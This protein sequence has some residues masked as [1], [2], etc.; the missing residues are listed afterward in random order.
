MQQQELFN[1][2]GVW[3]YFKHE[4]DLSVNDFFIRDILKEERHSHLGGG[5]GGRS[6]LHSLTYHYSSEAATAR[7]QTRSLRL[8]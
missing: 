4:R 1:Q 3:L 7:S 8:N 6:H 5:R 2:T